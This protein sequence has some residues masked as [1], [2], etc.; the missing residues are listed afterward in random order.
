MY[1]KSDQLKK[2]YPNT[3]QFLHYKG[4]SMVYNPVKQVLIL[5]KDQRPTRTRTLSELEDMENTIT[6]ELKHFKL[7][8]IKLETLNELL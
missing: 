3:F 5:N 4:W 1:S 6:R 2:D 8:E 7:E